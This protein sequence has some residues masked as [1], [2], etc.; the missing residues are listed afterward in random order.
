M[1]SIIIPSVDEMK[2]ESYERSAI[3]PDLSH[4]STMIVRNYRGRNAKLVM[5]PKSTRE[6]RGGGWEKTGAKRWDDA[7]ERVVGRKV[8]GRAIKSSG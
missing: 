4:F 5:K 6:G 8:K 1:G 3:Y 7:V 2:G